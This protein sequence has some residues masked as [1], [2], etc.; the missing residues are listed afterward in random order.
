MIG[1]AIVED[2]PVTRVGLAKVIDGAEDL[3]LLCA[4][5]SVEKFDSWGGERP[6]AVILDLR[7]RG[8]GIDGT[9]AIEHLDLDPLR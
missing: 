6:A 8:G 2:D 3:H 5:S 4:V 9:A 1:V 7:L